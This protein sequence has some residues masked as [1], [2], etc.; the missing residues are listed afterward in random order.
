MRTSSGLQVTVKILFL[1]GLSWFI[2]H[3]TQIQ[4]KF[5]ISTQNYLSFSLFSSTA[6]NISF[7]RRNFVLFLTEWKV[8]AVRDACTRVSIDILYWYS[9]FLMLMITYQAQQFQT[10]FFQTNKQ[11]NTTEII[12]STQYIQMIFAVV[13]LISHGVSSRMMLGIGFCT[14]KGHYNNCQQQQGNVP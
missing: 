7:L 13:F 4:F 5:V 10:D 12:K 8:S 14:F 11:A 6:Q 3:S 1:L 9:H 2:K